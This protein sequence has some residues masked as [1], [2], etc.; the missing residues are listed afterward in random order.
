MYDYIYIDGWLGRPYLFWM[1]R[2]C[3]DQHMHG[4]STIFL[5]SSSRVFLSIWVNNNR[6]TT[7]FDHV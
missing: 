7:S 4:P 6:G 3:H 5:R 1:Y 2:G